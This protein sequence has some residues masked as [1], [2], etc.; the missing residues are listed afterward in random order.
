MILVTAAQFRVDPGTLETL[1]VGDVLTVT[2]A[3]AHHAVRVRRLAAGE[4]VRCADGTGRGVAGVVEAAGPDGLTV[5]VTRLLDGSLAPAEAR[6]VLV[7]ALAKGGRD[8]L[9]VEAATE[10]GVD[11][12][13]AWQA[14]RSIVRWRAERA[15]KSLAKWQHLVNAAAK[16]ARRLSEPAVAGPCS[17]AD[18]VRRLA[19][20]REGGGAAYVLHGQAGQPLAGRAVPDAGDVVLVVGPEGG[21]A[22]GELAAFTEAGAI[23]VRLGDNVL[24]SSTAGP[25]ALAVLLAATRWGTSR[26]APGDHDERAGTP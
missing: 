13:L 15:G 14:E 10:L 8:E 25:A 18:V 17:T 5:R 11:E 20:A 26:P 23:P 16:Q 19:A 21:I 1:T 3:E 9:A 22:E 24:R 4:P 6:F 7:Q 12:V 2:G